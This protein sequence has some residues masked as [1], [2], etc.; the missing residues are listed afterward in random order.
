M[1]MAFLQQEWDILKGDVMRVMAE[2]YRNGVV[3][4]ITKETYI[5]LAPKG[6]VVRKVGDL[7]PI[8]LVTSLY[9]VISKVLS[10]RLREVLESIVSRN[11]GAFV[12]G[13]QIIDMALVANEAMEDYKSGGLQEQKKER[14]CIK[15][16][17]CQ[18][19]WS[20]IRTFWILF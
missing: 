13:R 20:W 16:G 5:A 3:N 15:V 18:G 8:S 12:Q 7:R 6:G 17:F 19:I 14:L 2:F 1:V 11:Q 9:K 4:S 10:L